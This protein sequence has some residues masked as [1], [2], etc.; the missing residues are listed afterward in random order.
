MYALGLSRMVLSTKA[1]TL[2]NPKKYEGENVLVYVDLDVILEND[3]DNFYIK[4]F[5][6]NEYL[7]TKIYQIADTIQHLIDDCNVN[8]IT[9]LSYLGN[10]DLDKGEDIKN[11]PKYSLKS[12]L[13]DLNSILPNHLKVTYCEN[14]DD[15][16]SLRS[17][18]EEKEEKESNETKIYLLENINLNEFDYI[19]SNSQSTISESAYPFL[20]KMYSNHTSYLIGSLSVAFRTTSASMMGKSAISFL[21]ISFSFIFILIQ[22]TFT[23]TS[24][25]CSAI[26][27][28]GSTR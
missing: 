12:I 8:S 28:Y 25:L 23:Y 11:N 2:N 19:N 1:N 22:I 16:I 5:G 10:P 20:Q 3:S 9:L 4:R 21:S 6:T 18:G 17:L 13:S 24:S 14:I 26:R 15:V 7:P 27:S